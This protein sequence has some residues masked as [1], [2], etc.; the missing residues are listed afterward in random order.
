M[1]ILISQYFLVYQ[2]YSNGS[3][4]GSIEN[5][6][7]YILFVWDFIVYRKWQ[8]TNIYIYIYIYIK[9][10]GIYQP[11]NLMSNGS[12]RHDDAAQTK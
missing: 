2:H 6:F 10:K 9:S 5:I 3:T 11:E 1:Y 8:I 7:Y 12:S 4:R